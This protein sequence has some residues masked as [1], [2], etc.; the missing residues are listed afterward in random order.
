ML[1]KIYLHLHDVNR[2]PWAV[3]LINASRARHVKQLLYGGDCTDLFPGLLTDA[4]LWIGGDQVEQGY[5]DQGEAGADGYFERIVGWA[6]GLYSRVLFVEGPNEPYVATLAALQRLLAFYRR[7]YRRWRAH[8]RKLPALGFGNFSNGNPDVTNGAMM[9]ALAA[10]LDEV[11]PP[12]LLLHQYGRP[13]LLQGMDDRGNVMGPEWMPLRH[14]V[15]LPALKAA[16]CRRIPPIFLTEFGVDGTGSP[17]G[18]RGWRSLYRSFEAYLQDL[19][20][21]DNALCEDPDVVGAALWNVGGTDQWADFEHGETEVRRILALTAPIATPAPQPEPQPEPAPAP[22]PTPAPARLEGYAGVH[23]PTVEAFAEWMRE[24]QPDIRRFVAHHTVTPTA[25]QWRGRASLEGAEAFYRN[26]RKWRVGPALFVAPDGIWALH[27]PGT[28]NRGAGWNSVKDL[29]DGTSE[30]ESR[31]ILNVEV[32]GDFRQAAPSGR[33]RELF[34]GVLAV[35]L[36]QNE[37]DLGY[38]C[39]YGATE[40]PGAAFIREWPAMRQEAAIQ[41]AQWR[42]QPAW[43][44]G[45]PEHETA[46]DVATLSTKMRAWLEEEKRLREAGRGERADQV[47]DSLIVLAMRVEGIA[48]TT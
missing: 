3:P 27:L 48:N 4:R 29:P 15:L 25:E 17:L 33:L 40:C 10:F 43:Y 26:T 30:G 42:P 14:R 19:Q 37:P 2:A 35:V 38:H 47:H 21:A 1:R 11:Q 36:S 6:E 44:P 22:A 45:L 24:R 23:W 28:L 7:L 12:Y 13:L 18:R 20:L 31:F 32:T 34:V 9:Q 46:T 41:A 39:M 8:P 5:I 16:G